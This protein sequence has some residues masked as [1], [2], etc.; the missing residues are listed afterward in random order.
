[1]KKYRWIFAMGCMLVYFVTT[2]DRI[3]LSISAT[4]IM[5]EFGLNATQFG[6][7]MGAMMPCFALFNIIGGYF[8]D[9]SSPSRIVKWSIAI[10]SMT[11]AWFCWIATYPWMIINRLF[12]G[13]SEGMGSPMQHKMGVSWMLPNERGRLVGLGAAASVMGVTLGAP[14]CATIVSYYDWR[15][16]FYILAV[17][18]FVCVGILHVIIRDKPRDHKWVSKEELELIESSLEKER[19]GK[20]KETGTVSTKQDTINLLKSTYLWLGCFSYATVYM[21]WWA[22]ISWL[23]GYL[24]AEKGFTVLKSGWLSSIPYL[25]GAIGMVSGGFITDHLSKGKRMPFLIL[26]QLIGPP[27]MFFA[28]GATSTPVMITAFA[29]SNFFVSGALGQI[30][31]FFMDIFPT[32]VVSQSVG[33]GNAV[34]AV[35]GFFAPIIMG[36]IFDV[37]KSFYWGFGLLAIVVFL[38]AIFS[39]PLLVKELRMHKEAK[40]YAEKV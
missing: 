34:G 37:T 27:I 14:F 40:L 7:I 24:V 8:G 12:F 38:G 5:K 17:F 30:Y 23:P 6:V 36:R 4:T 9:R 3:N 1:M 35:L 19:K 16:L 26:C 15:T 39:I 22:N 28:L 25:I 29:V 21:L 11:L 18:G 20:G 33:I 32:K 2:I 31:P 13:A 10:W